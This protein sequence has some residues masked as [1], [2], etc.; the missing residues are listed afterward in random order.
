MVKTPSTLPVPPFRRIRDQ[1]GVS[2]TAIAKA[3]QMTQSNVWMYE[4]RGQS[5]PPDV[6]KALIA[7]AKTLGHKLTYNNIYES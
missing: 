5:I 3:L 7:Y 6:A 2:Q 1:L 4:N